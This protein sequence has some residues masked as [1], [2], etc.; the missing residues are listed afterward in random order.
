MAPRILTLGLLA[1]GCTAPPPELPAQLVGGRVELEP[2]GRRLAFRRAHPP[3]IRL[4]RPTPLVAELRG[5]AATP[6][7]VEP[8]RAVG[9]GF[10]VR[11]VLPEG[12]APEPA[13]L[14]ARRADGAEARWTIRVV[15]HNDEQPRRAAIRKARRAGRY[16]EASRLLDGFVAADLDEQIW[17]RAERAR[18]DAGRGEIDRAVKGLVSAASLADAR[19]PSDAAELLAIAAWYADRARWPTTRVI[20]LNRRAI[21]RAESVGDDARMADALA[22]LARAERRRGRLA[23]ADRHLREAQRR[24]RRVGAAGVVGRVARA[25]S[26]LLFRLGRYS[27]AAAVGL[28]PE[29]TSA[30]AR[31]NT[32]W[33]RLL[34]MEHGV[35]PPDFVALVDRFAALAEGVV[36]PA[37]LANLHLNRARAAYLAGAPAIADEA[38]AD[39]RRA[40]PDGAGFEPGFADLLA[41]D[42]ALLR[43]DPAAAQAAYRDAR[44][45]L[46]PE[47]AWQAMHGE[48]QALRAAS[49]APAAIERWRAAHAAQIAMAGRV[50]LSSDRGAFVARQGQLARDLAGL[51]IARGDVAEALT[52]LDAVA[53]PTLRALVVD[54]RLARLDPAALAEWSARIDRWRAA[55][56]GVEAAVER[57]SL[58]PVDRRPLARDAVEQAR[59]GAR[60]ALDEAWAWLDAR[61]PGGSVDDIRAVVAALPA[62]AAA[63][64]YHRLD[65]GWHGF[66]VVDGTVRHRR[67]TDN[68]VLGPWRAI[69]EPRRALYVA[70]GGLLAARALSAPDRAAGRVARVPFIGWLGIRR[71]PPT[72]APL[73][74]ADPDGTLP[75]SREAALAI[76][77]ANG[78]EPLVG[79]AATRD[80]VLARLDGTRWL[81]FDGHGVAAGDPWEAELVL[82]GG[83]SL[84]L[85][86]LVAA[87]PRVGLVLLSACDAGRRLELA[88]GEGLTLADGFLLAGADTVVAADRP[89]GVDEASV[90]VRA[91]HRHGVDRDPAG[92]L[93]ATVAE[94]RAGGYDL[95]RGWS[96][97][98]RL[99]TP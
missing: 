54:G 20:E 72:G 5:A 85:A 27:A 79:Q 48:G 68:D 94:L 65:D 76:A 52:V 11:V 57:L 82:A 35:V 38:L 14:V 73:V 62:D 56:R 45:T 29:A 15:P 39:A 70:D 17:A 36:D 1:L 13:T 98:G 80:A 60:A 66:L 63:L 7:A 9:D 47:Q 19:R 77:R 8:P 44:E 81:H 96:V 83:E 18:V 41:G 43:G 34:A 42:V 31:S 12:V 46:G 26:D 55:R 91:L 75:V 97:Y 21:A 22:P 95:W 16:G 86:D 71:A 87:R 28:A 58:S 99:P 64:G 61:A 93:R 78:V 40:D 53:A 67:I 74:V 89:L 90:M 6:L 25:R 69:V 4:D 3:H 33:L 23:I 88:G 24:A 59:R 30:R 51:L 92:A 37:S 32:A 49:D 84:T 2:A 10:L 50:S